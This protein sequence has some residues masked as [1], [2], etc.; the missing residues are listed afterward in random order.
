VTSRFYGGSE[1]LLS[2]Y[3]WYLKNSEEHSWPVGITKP[4]DFGLFDTLGNVFCWC[5]ERYIDS[6]QS[7]DAAPS[8]DVEDALVINNQE[9]RV[10]R[11]AAYDVTASYLRCASRHDYLP[12]YHVNTAGFRVAR[13]FTLH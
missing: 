4:N 12:T 1:K 5:Q 13:T 10:L 3:G 11:G 7:K 6:P 8:A 9:T 2:K